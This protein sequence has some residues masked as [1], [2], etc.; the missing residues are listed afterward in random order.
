ME[1]NG[2][3]V[4]EETV[5][6]KPFLEDVGNGGIGERRLFGGVSPKKKTG[7]GATGW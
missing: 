5:A 3:G 6:R 2:D 7:N 1:S 4:A